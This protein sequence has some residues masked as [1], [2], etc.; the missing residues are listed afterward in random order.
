MPRVVARTSEDK[1]NEAL[2][3]Q[4]GLVFLIVP[5]LERGIWDE[6]SLEEPFS[7]N[8]EAVLP[9]SVRWPTEIAH[10]MRTCH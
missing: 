7:V 2:E 4:G 5:E 8:E 3:V 6:E 10:L 1:I 9:L